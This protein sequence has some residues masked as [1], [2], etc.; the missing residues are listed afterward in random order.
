VSNFLRIAASLIDDNYGRVFLVRKRGTAAF[1]QAGGKIEDGESPL[2]ALVR[3]L[4]EE[5]HFTP[6]ENEAKFL[7]RFS[8]AAG[9]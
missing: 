2:E 3:E 8:C 4:T 9:Q 6:S 7:G 1:M 5:L